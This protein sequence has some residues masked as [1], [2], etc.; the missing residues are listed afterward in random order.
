MINLSN[1][2]L[3]RLIGE[4]LLIQI[5]LCYVLIYACF[6]GCISNGAYIF[7]ISLLGG[8][9][10][11]C[12]PKLNNKTNWIA[13]GISL[14]SWSIS[15]IIGALIT[16][17]SYD[18]NAYHQEIIAALCDGWKAGEN[19]VDGL[20][21]SIWS[22]HYAR[23]IEMME[24]AVVAFT[25]N[26]ESGKAL[27]FIIGIS[28]FLLVYSFVREKFPNVDNKIV[29]LCVLVAVC[30]PVYISQCLTYY[31]D[32]AKYFYTLISI[33]FIFEIASQPEKIRG[34]IML[35]VVIIFAIETKFNAFFEEGVVIFASIVWLFFSKKKKTAIRL[36][37]C[38]LLSAVVGVFVLGYNP[39]VSNYLYA[40]HPLYPL[41][42]EGSIDI[43]TNNT[44]DIYLGHNRIYTFFS[45]LFTK[46]IPIYDTREGGFGPLMFA[47]ILISLWAIWRNR[48]IGKGILIYISLWVI[49]SCF[50]FEQSWWA[51]YICQLWLIVSIGTI[52]LIGTSGFYKILLWLQIAGVG[53]TTFVI[54]SFGLYLTI[55]NDLYRKTILS[56]ISGREVEVISLNEGY[57]RQMK[58]RGK[59]IVISISDEDSRGYMMPYY[60]YSVNSKKYPILLLDSLTRSNIL[61]KL[62]D[63]PFNYVIKFETD[64]LDKIVR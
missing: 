2:S 38:G 15:I 40:G 27:N 52:V 62:D 1:I 32:Y 44:P 64:S 41:M 60:G 16:D 11:V 17:Y 23:G 22:Q 8:F 24:A 31:I 9:L 26:I 46:A 7:P 50:F 57:R 28:S 35:G 12:L 42:G 19:Y 13:F 55:R 29:V 37:L 4:M 36:A 63:T 30:N 47:M 48:N 33:I 3:A 56:E 53:I 5:F 54:I 25:G 21:M 14:L 45:S 34:Y 18:G 58:E 6:M 61:L 59:V 10:A 20:K 39:Y 43:M 51:R 49:A